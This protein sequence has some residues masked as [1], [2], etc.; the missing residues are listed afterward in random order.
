M[1]KAI[2]FILASAAII[3]LNGFILEYCV[4]RDM[5]EIV[6]TVGLIALILLDIIYIRYVVSVIMLALEKPYKKKE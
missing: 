5:P 3:F 1:Q 2:T 4:S 6:S